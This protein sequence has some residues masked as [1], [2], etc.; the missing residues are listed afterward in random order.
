MSVFERAGIPCPQDIEE[1][2]MNARIEMLLDRYV[3][4]KIQKRSA[5]K[6]TAPMPWLRISMNRDCPAWNAV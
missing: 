6:R 2:D 1:D 5:G 3:V 4:Q